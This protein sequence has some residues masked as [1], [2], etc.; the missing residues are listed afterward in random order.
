MIPPALSAPSFCNPAFVCG[1]HEVTHR[2]QVSF[3]DYTVSIQPI[4]NLSWH[5]WGQWA[6]SKHRICTS[7]TEG[8]VRGE[9]V[10]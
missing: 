9:C 5:L 6:A 2:A 7:D 1:L 8:I 10:C 4:G 3:H